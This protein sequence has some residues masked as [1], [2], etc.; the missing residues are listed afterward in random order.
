MESKAE[1]KDVGVGVEDLTTGAKRLRH[2]G[3]PQVPKTSGVFPCTS[4]FIYL[5]AMHLTSRESLHAP[6]A[7]FL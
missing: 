3:A 2:A 7:L 6:A 4:N 1:V 5:L